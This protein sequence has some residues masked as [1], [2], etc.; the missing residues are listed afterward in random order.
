MQGDILYSRQ[1]VFHVLR[2][3]ALFKVDGQNNLFSFACQGEFLDDIFGA[4]G[5]STDSKD[6]QLAFMDSLDDFLGPHSGAMDVGFIHPHCQPLLT[7][8]LHQ[9]NNLMLI[10]S[11]VTNENFRA[12]V[13]CG[14]GLVAFSFQF[15]TSLAVFAQ[16][17]VCS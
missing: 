16:D 13:F 1:L 5:V 7:Q 8:I 12:Q 9:P 11:R 2:D 6:E 17:G 10:L 4:G 14:V 3:I 15:F